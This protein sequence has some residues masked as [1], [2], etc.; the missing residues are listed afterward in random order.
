MFQWRMR[1]RY[2]SM[3]EKNYLI[4]LDYGGKTHSIQNLSHN[5]FTKGNAGDC[6]WVAETIEDYIKENR[7]HRD[8]EFV[9][10]IRLF[11]K[12]GELIFHRHDF[13]E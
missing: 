7:L 2:F 13:K 9:T 12:N 1:D 3:N 5:D 8:N 4:Q 6:L 10:N 11:G